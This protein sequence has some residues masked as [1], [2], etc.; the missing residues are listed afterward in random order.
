MIVIC[1]HA[2]DIGN[3][4]T[5]FFVCITVNQLKLYIS[6]TNWFAIPATALIKKANGKHLNFIGSLKY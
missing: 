6:Q 3:T 5:K 4:T 2:D 1:M